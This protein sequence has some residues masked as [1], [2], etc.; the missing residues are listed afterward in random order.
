MKTLPDLEKHALELVR[1]ASTQ[2]PADIVEALERGRDAEAEGSAARATLDTVLENIAMAAEASTPICQ[3]TGT[4]IFYVRHPWD[5]PT[6]PMREAMTAAVREATARSYLRPN[7]V[8]SVTGANSGDNS[9]DHFPAFYFEQWDREDEVRVDLMLKGGGS[10][11]QG[12]QYSLPDR[13]LGAG[14]DLDGVRK[15]VLDALVRA[16]GHGCG[17]AVVGVCIGGDRGGSIAVAKRQILRPLAHRNPDATLAALEDELHARA[18]ELGIGPMG[19][20][21]ATTVLG[22]KI[23]KAHRLPASF[24]VSVVYMCWAARRHAMTIKAGEVSYD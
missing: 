21:G 1:L 7:A 18:N 12:I 10:E 23:A 24:F 6:A 20:G 22:V 4:P 11:N 8:D 9:G 14:R 13:D 15:A 2:L 5:H 19:F 16:Q 3:D 17:P